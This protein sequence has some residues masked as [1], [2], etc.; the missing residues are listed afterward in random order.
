MIKK[1]DVVFFLLCLTWLA[2]F[3]VSMISDYKLS[4]FL[5][6]EVVSFLLLVLMYIDYLSGSNRSVINNYK[7]SIK[8]ITIILMLTAIIPAVTLFYSLN[9]AYGFLKLVSMITS[10]IPCLLVLYYIILTVNQDRL[11]I[12]I[13]SVLFTSVTLAISSLI[14]KPFSFISPYSFSLTNWSHV[15]FARFISIAIILIL[16]VHFCLVRPLH[17][18]ISGLTIFILL[19]GLLLSGHKASIPGVIFISIFL[20]FYYSIKLS[21]RNR[22]IYTSLIA[23]ILSIAFMIIVSGNDE[24]S[25]RAAT[26]LEPEKLLMEDGVVVRLDIWERALIVASDN[27][28]FGVGLGGFNAEEAIGRELLEIKYAHNLPLEIYVELGIVPFLL[29]LFLLFQIIKKSYSTGFE[30]T[31]MLLY[32]FW[33]SLFSKDLATNTQVWLAL[34][35]LV[36]NSDTI[37]RIKESFKRL[38]NAELDKR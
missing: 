25:R 13:I 21:W 6:K 11:R 14:L 37:E 10:T 33:L 9:P 24:A 16:F 12:F 34:I 31:I 20:I 28:P 3:F 38:D 35:L 29:F 7:K 22:A 27:F 17:L 19:S 2:S 18:Y 26:L 15:L 23:L 5:L 36:I 4:T 8:K 30:I 32:F 1:K